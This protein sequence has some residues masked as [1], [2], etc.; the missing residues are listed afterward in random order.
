VP[1]VMAMALFALPINGSVDCTCAKP[2]RTCP[3]EVGCLKA[4]PFG[5]HV[6]EIEPE[7]PIELEPEKMRW[8]A[9]A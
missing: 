9:D 2:N 7:A 5:R 3:A 6:D 8:G 4:G 1:L